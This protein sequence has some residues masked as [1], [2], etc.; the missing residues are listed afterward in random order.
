MFACQ[1]VEFLNM[2]QMVW[3]ETK[4]NTLNLN[5]K[6]NQALNPSNNYRYKLRIL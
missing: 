5:F 6:L 3:F 4:K 1:N 2:A